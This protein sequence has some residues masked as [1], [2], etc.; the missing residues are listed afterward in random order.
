MKA[1]IVNRLS[2]LL[3]LVPFLFFV[4]SCEGPMGQA[5]EDGIAGVDG[6]NGIDGDVTCQACH[7]TGIIQDVSSQFVE[8]I[9]SSGE[10]AVSYAGGRSYCARCHSHEGFR[11]FVDT[12]TVSGN[13]TAPSAWECATCHQLHET[14]A[15]SIDWNRRITAPVSFIFDDA[16]TADFGEGNICATCHQSRRAEPNITDPGT[17]FEITSTHYGPHHGAQSNVLY[18]AG[19][20][21]IAGSMAYDDPGSATHF[22]GASC[23]SCHMGEYDG[24][25]GGHTFY[26][27]VSSCTACHAGAT[28]F[29]INGVRTA[30]KV[31]L[32]TLQSLLLSQGVIEE[33]VEEIF[34]L[35]EETGDII[36]VLVSDGY[37]PVVGTFTMAQSQA[38]FNWIGLLEDR[39]LGVHNPAYYEAL[40]TNS[41]EAIQP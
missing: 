40:L 9:H 7:S 34:E 1:H 30:I 12:E 10:V 35:D 2:S 15:D 32:D 5:G 36:P 24:G 39:S 31:Q 20:A 13:I 23:T 11:E 4:I 17:E 26:P 22:S 37:H 19:M 3:V 27:S 21:E 41:I 6:I 18:G 16:V 33:A 28:D 8:S 29:D 14:F 25:T 38:F